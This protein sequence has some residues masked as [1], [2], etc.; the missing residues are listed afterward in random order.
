MRQR[1]CVRH[2]DT[3]A[4]LVAMDGATQGS[5]S[6]CCRVQT[7]SGCHAGSS[8]GIPPPSPAHLAALAER[9]ARLPLALR[10][11]AELANVRA[12]TPEA[13]FVEEL[14]DQW[15]RPVVSD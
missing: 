13:E 14:V 12:R 4:G 7:R 6:T 15:Q 1:G 3:L 2:N 10:V 11:A 9:C 8:A 5:T